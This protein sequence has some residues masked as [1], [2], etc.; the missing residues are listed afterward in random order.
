RLGDICMFCS[1]RARS[2]ASEV[3]TRLP[4]C[5]ACE[6]IKVPKI[7]NVNLDRLYVFSRDLEDLFKTLESRENL[8]HRLY[9]W[10]DIEPMVVDGYLKNKLNKRNKRKPSSNAP[11]PFNPEEYAEFCFEQF[12]NEVCDWS[13]MSRNFPKISL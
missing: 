10:S 9:R 13:E 4:I 12:N 11:I 5:Q 1:N 3:F 2:S 6:A 8:D 7:S